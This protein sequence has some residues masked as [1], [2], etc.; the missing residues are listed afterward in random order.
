MIDALLPHHAWFAQ[1]TIPSVIENDE[2]AVLGTNPESFYAVPQC[3][4]M[5]FV[6]S[7]TPEEVAARAVSS[8]PRR[9]N[10]LS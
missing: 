4:D 8:P 1:G 9:S 10:R 5:T 6:I 7:L 3:I 2:D